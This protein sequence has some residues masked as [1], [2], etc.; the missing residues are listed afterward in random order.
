MSMHYHPCKA[1]VVADALSRL[2]MGTV[3]HVEEERKDLV[4]DVYRLARLGIRL[5]SISDSGVT[6]QNGAESSL[7]VEV[8]SQGGDGVLRY[9]DRLCVPDVGELRKHI[10]VEAHYSRY[11][12]HLGAT[13]MYRDLREVYWWSG[14]K[15][16]IEDLVSKYPNCQ[17]VNI[18]HQ[19]LG[20]MTQEIDIP[21]W[22]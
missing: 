21:T 20:G 14:M 13:K 17:Q 9:Q 16:D 1:N 2:S 18:E 3:A 15:R 19:K 7:R 8:F 22:K 12:I 11:S 5:M 6:V 4:K 10:L